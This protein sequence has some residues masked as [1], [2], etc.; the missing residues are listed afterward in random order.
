MVFDIIMCGFK[1]PELFQ[2]IAKTRDHNMTD[3]EV[4]ALSYH[5][6]CSMLNFNPVIVA[7]H[8]QYR[9]ETFFREVLLSNANPIGKIVYYALRIEFQMRGSPHCFNMDI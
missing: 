4:E 1:M 3:E 9:V 8:F 2:I 5:E 7:K 6:R